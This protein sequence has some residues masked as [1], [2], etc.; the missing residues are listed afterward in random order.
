MKL[1][2]VDKYPLLFNYAYHETPIGTLVSLHTIEGLLSHLFFTRN[3]FENFKKKYSPII[4]EPL[5]PSSIHL[6]SLQSELAGY[7]SGKLTKFSIPL[8]LKGTN[9]QMSVWKGLL[10]IPYGSSCSYLDLA[11]KIKHPK[12]VRA[13]GSAN[14]ANPIP[15]IIPCHRVIAH[16]GGLGGYGGGLAIKSFLLDLE[17]TSLYP[18]HLKILPC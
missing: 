17:K 18:S 16:N 12:A 8:M 10:S 9:F 15:V 13:L 1:V 5:A 2:I 7:F 11:V 14:G 6:E 4:F 3:D